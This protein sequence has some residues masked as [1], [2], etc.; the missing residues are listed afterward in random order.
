[1]RLEKKRHFIP[2]FI[3]TQPMFDLFLYILP[4]KTPLHNIVQQMF[5]HAR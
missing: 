3:S 4:F 5:A 2:T 1:M